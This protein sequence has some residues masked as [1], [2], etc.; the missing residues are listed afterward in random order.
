MVLFFDDLFVVDLSV[1]DVAQQRGETRWA[2]EEIGHELRE[3]LLGIHIT[4][5][6]EQ[7]QHVMQ[8][9]NQ[10]NILIVLEVILKPRKFYSFNSLD[11]LL[12]LVHLNKQRPA[13]LVESIQVLHFLLILEVEQLS[14]GVPLIL[15]FLQSQAQFLRLRGIFVLAVGK[16]VVPL[17]KSI[18]DGG[19]VHEVGVDMID[20]YHHLRTDLTIEL[21]VQHLLLFVPLQHPHELLLQLVVEVVCL[22][23]PL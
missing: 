20:V 22:R 4:L 14:K 17:R 11:L 2:S 21:E 3:F 12:Y 6:V 15:P 8:G 19:N 13:G 7:R 23:H 10:R 16:Q 9:L 5:L 1:A 18:D